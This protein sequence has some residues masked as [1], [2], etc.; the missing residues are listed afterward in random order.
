MARVFIL[1]ASVLQV[2][3]IEAAKAKGHWVLVADLDPNAA[4]IPLADA[5]VLASTIDE[6]AVP[7]AAI[8]H[9]VDAVLTTATDQPLRA[10]AKACAACG[11]PGLSP[12]VALVV[13]RKDLMRQVLSRGGVACPVSV[14][15]RDGDELAAAWRTIRGPVIV[16]PVDSSGSRGVTLVRDVD[17][18]QPALAHALRYSGAKA[19]VAEEFMVG[20]EFSVETLSVR[21]QLHVL[22]ITDKETTGPPHF[23]ESGHSQPA[24][25]TP[26]EQTSI[27][28]LT[29][30]AANAL[31]ILSG[32]THTEVMLTSQG[33]RIVEVGARPGGDYITSD[34]VPLS[35]GID[36]LSLVLDLSLGLEVKVPEP[37]RKGAAIRYFYPPPGRIRAIE[38]VEAAR[39][40]QGV[41][42][43]E[44]LLHEGQTVVPV[45]G[46]HQRA[47]Y[48]IACCESVDH[49]V[50]IAER[51]RA[52]VSY[53]VSQDA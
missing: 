14:P 12:E 53:A 49:A 33:P 51:C 17:D 8:S 38:G 10:A 24:K 31:G 44:S 21:G 34:L 4:G 45:T 43:V 46:S 11:L 6:D 50:R 15:V 27:A 1:G 16:K 25:L 19:A 5:F 48:A 35:T 7:R 32:P 29:R 52:M 39:A 20:R 36:M 30:A 2:P 42:R 13:T 26:A 37:Q 9:R 41:V 3:L 47:G 40:L 23:V 28:E 18:L 22:Q